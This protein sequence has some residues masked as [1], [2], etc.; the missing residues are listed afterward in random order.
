MNI[1]YVMV[2]KTWYNGD[3]SFVQPFQEMHGARQW[4]KIYCIVIA[5]ESQQY[6]QQISC[7]F[8]SKLYPTKKFTSYL[9]L[10]YLIY[11]IFAKT[12]F[13]NTHITYKMN[14]Y[15][16]KYFGPRK[17]TFQKPFMLVMVLLKFTKTKL[18]TY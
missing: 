14:I 9:F 1:N 3:I 15:G 11:I 7:W 8:L 12:S 17:G 13:W 16:G 6:P 4:K 10:H 2:S 18:I 5:K